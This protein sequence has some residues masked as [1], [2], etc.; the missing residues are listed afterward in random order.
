ML[1]RYSHIRMT[2]KRNAMDGITLPEPTAV[3]AEEKQ[4]PELDKLRVQ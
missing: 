3:P 1:E 2:A 4:E